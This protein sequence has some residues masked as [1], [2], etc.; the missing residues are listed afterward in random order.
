M[1]E[2][3]DSDLSNEE[4]DDTYINDGHV[5]PTDSLDERSNDDVFKS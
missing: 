3:N 2:R 1:T 5:E 4:D